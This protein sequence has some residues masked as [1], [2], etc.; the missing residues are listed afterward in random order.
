MSIIYNSF[1]KNLISSDIDLTK[2]DI[3]A[4]LVSELYEPLPSH[5]YKDV[6][7]FEIESPNYKSGGNSLYITTNGNSKVFS[8]KVSWKDLT[9]KIKFIVLYKN[10][11][12]PYPILC[13]DLGGIRSLNNN[14]FS[15]RW[16]DFLLEFT[17]GEDS[18]KIENTSILGSSVLGKMVLGMSIEDK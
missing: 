2:D 16:D 14:N 11:E 13:Q 18:K 4:I 12:E 17:Q 5:D 15:I 1:F 8:A 7:P 3:K 6:T 10:C 9:A